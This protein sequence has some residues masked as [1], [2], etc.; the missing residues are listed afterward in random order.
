MVH[1]NLCSFNAIIYKS[2]DEKITDQL[3]TRVYVDLL[4]KKMLQNNIKIYMSF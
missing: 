1:F 2:L 3:I 4:M